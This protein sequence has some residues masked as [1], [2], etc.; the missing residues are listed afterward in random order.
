MPLLRAR[1]GQWPR[2]RDFSSAATSSRAAPPGL[3]GSSSAGTHSA[4]C[5]TSMSCGARIRTAFRNLIFRSFMPASVAGRDGHPLSIPQTNFDRRN[6]ETRR[7]SCPRI[8]R[9]RNVREAL[10]NPETQRHRVTKSLL[11]NHAAE[12]FTLSASCWPPTRMTQHLMPA[13]GPRAFQPDLNRR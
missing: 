1:L 2:G 6:M 4:N 11:E 7:G 13:N 3:A 8:A 9:M 5:R 12:A 10:K